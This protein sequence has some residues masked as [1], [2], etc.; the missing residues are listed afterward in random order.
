MASI[1]GVSLKNIKNFKGH[2]GEPCYQANIYLNNKKIGYYSD[3]AW[4]AICLNLHFDSKENEEKINKI[5]E[6][7]GK[8][9]D[10]LDLTFSEQY[11]LN[12][13]LDS[14]IEDIL[15][16]SLYEKDFK[17]YQ[18]KYADFAGVVIGE[19]YNYLLS[20]K[21]NFKEKIKHLS[22]IPFLKLEDFIIE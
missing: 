5:A 14:F 9:P 3:D 13:T 12:Y 15:F 4:G 20:T 8:R 22:G 7:Y 1:C 21:E 2:E 6:E 17:K 19:Q 11:N 10:K 18:K 16:L